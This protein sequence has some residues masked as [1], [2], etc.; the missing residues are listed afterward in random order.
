MV[1]R[2]QL[3]FHFGQCRMPPDAVRRIRSTPA[4]SLFGRRIQINLHIGIG[5]H[6]RADIA[7]FDDDAGAFPLSALPGDEY[8]T[9][10][11]QPRRHSG[12]TIDLRRA[13][14]GG[15]V[16]TVDLHRGRADVERR[17][18]GEGCNGV[19]VVQCEPDLKRFPRHGTIHGAGVQMPVPE[20][21]RDGARDRAFAG[22]GRAV[23]RDDER[24]HDASPARVGAKAKR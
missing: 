24:T 5:K 23:D 17:A 3:A 2:L 21:L 16:A 19:F 8:R 18:L 11:R 9:D 20:P 10:F 12:G 4:R 6:D 1:A 13:D 14:R 15:D 22:S 7:P